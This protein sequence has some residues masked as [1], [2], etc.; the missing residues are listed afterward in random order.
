MG[1][2]KGILKI[3]AVVAVTE[4]VRRELSKPENQQKVRQLSD[5]AKEKFREYTK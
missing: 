1:F 3:G 5:R 2:I 4:V